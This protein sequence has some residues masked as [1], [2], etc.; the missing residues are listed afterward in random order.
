M[1]YLL[2][3]LSLLL[4]SFTFTGCSSVT[5]SISGAG[6]A[7]TITNPSKASRVSDKAYISEEKIKFAPACVSKEMLRINDSFKVYNS[8]KGRATGVYEYQDLVF[9]IVNVAYGKEKTAQKLAKGTAMLRAKH[10]LQTTYKLPSK[11][12]LRTHQLE[13]IDFFRKKI[14]RY[15]FVCLKKDINAIVTSKVKNKR[16]ANTSNRQEISSVPKSS[17]QQT[18]VQKVNKSK[19]AHKR[20]VNSVVFSGDKNISNDF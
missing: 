11:Y 3:G 17:I 7:E 6:S 18:P 10:L 9:V 2:I 20:H 19:S 4:I 14:Y 8:S 15:A 13:A 5:N 12:N 1:K 16:V